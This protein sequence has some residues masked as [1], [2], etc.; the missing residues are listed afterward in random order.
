MQ[1][2]ERPVGLET[3]LLD[4]NVIGEEGAQSLACALPGSSLATLGLSGNDVGVGAVAIASALP[5]SHLRHLDL[6]ASSLGDVE[7]TALGNALHRSHLEVL[8]VS[9]NE[10][11][12]IGVASICENCA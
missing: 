7:A 12:A 10:I 6:S 11:S 5:S 3:L 4:R 1:Q 9:S 2:A 8:D